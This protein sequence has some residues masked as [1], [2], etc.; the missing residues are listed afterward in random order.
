MSNDAKEH[1]AASKEDELSKSIQLKAHICRYIQK[2]G[3]ITKQI[4]KDNFK[5]TKLKELYDI[6]QH[7]NDEFFLITHFTKLLILPNSIRSEFDNMTN[8]LGG[9]EGLL[10]YLKRAVKAASNIETLKTSQIE[11]NKISMIEILLDVQERVFDSTLDTGATILGENFSE[12]KISAKIVKTRGQQKRFIPNKLKLT[13]SDPHTAKEIENNEFIL[14]EIDSHKVM[15]KKQGGK[16]MRVGN[17]TTFEAMGFSDNALQEDFK[18]NMKDVYSNMEFTPY[19]ANMVPEAEPMNKLSNIIIAYSALEYEIERSNKLSKEFVTQFLTLY[20]K[21]YD[22]EKLQVAEMQQKL[23]QI[24]VN[25]LRKW[26][27]LAQENTK[28]VTE[29]GRYVHT[30]GVDAASTDANEQAPLFSIPKMR[31]ERRADIKMK[32]LAR[33]KDGE[34]RWPGYPKSEE[35][36]RN[37]QPIQTV[38]EN[39]KISIH[40]TKIIKYISI[41]Q[42]DE[43]V[44][45]ANIIYEDN[46][47][48]KF[49]PN[50]VEYKT[51]Y[52]RIFGEFSQENQKMLDHAKQRFKISTSQP[53]KKPDKDNE[54]IKRLKNTLLFDPETNNFY[55]GI[56]ISYND[57]S[58]MLNETQTDNF[59]VRLYE[60]E[61]LQNK[62]TAK[63]WKK[64]T[65]EIAQAKLGIDV[66]SDKNTVNSLLKK[67][68]KESNDSDIWLSKNRLKTQDNDKNYLQ[69]TDKENLYTPLFPRLKFGSVETISSKDVDTIHTHSL[70]VSLKFKVYK[71]NS[72][73]YSLTLDPSYKAI[74]KKST[75]DKPW[76]IQVQNFS[77]RDKTIRV[78]KHNETEQRILFE[79]S[80]LETM[81]KSQPLVTMLRMDRITQILE[82]C[83]QT[84]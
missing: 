23:H 83:T 80:A 8:Q 72:K 44:I 53:N 25:T 68:P 81:T 2:E 41:I 7:K 58:K 31:S 21:Y 82:L 3:K 6:I 64:I 24:I 84:T 18:I 4:F 50:D 10:L 20:D 9:E 67:D 16:P 40:P 77:L 34:R 45:F 33:G 17:T 54:D 78:I 73:L 37:N 59:S 66:S 13:P 70:S 47:F 57:I 62:I 1:N 46:S 22:G 39:K 56:H 28:G 36:E 74:D 30:D 38:Q 14:S 26:K 12:G 35:Y 43:N 15:F 55:P 61:V 19:S 11:S 71:F 63:R 76:G 75:S 49:P 79:K 51:A 48:E 27:R 5:K 32:L 65:K 60:K 52:N 42:R 29:D 69:Y